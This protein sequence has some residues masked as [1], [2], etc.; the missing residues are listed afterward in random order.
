MPNHVTTRCIVT[1][2]TEDIKQAADKIYTLFYDTPP[3]K[4]AK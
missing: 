2:S 3:E 1:D 4:E